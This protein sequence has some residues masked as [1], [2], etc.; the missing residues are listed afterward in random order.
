MLKLRYEQ[1]PAQKVDAIFVRGAN[2]N[3]WLQAIS[4]LRIALQELQC[5]VVP[6]SIKV[7]EPAG[8]F[9]IMPGNKEFAD[10]FVLGPYAKVG[11]KLFIPHNSSLYPVIDINELNELLLWDYQF[12][13]PS[14]GLIGFEKK[15]R[16]D[17]VSLICEINLASTDWSF[18]NIG[19]P[20]RP[21]LTQ[22]LVQQP[23]MQEILESFK[24]EIDEKPL[25]EIPKEGGTNFFEKAFDEFKWLL[26]KGI[27]GIASLSEKILNFGNNQDSKHPISGK[28]GVIQELKQWLIQNI[29]NIEKKRSDELNRLLRMFDENTDKALQYAIPL[30]SPYLKRGSGLKSHSLVRRSLNFNLRNLGGG[31]AVDGWDVSNH[32]YDLRAKYLKAAEKE[33]AQ[34]DFRKAA[35]VYAHL[36]GDYHSAANVLEQG[37]FYREAAAL[38]KD[39]FKNKVAAAECLERGGLFHEA[40]PLFEEVN[41]Y[42][43]VG[44]LY[45]LLSQKERAYSYYQKTLDIKLA[46]NDYLDAARI[47]EQKM[48]NSDNAKEILLT[49]WKGYH[50]TEQCLNGY[51]DLVQST[52]SD[53]IS[54]KVHEVYHYCTPPSKRSVF[55]SVLNRVNQKTGEKNNS[56]REIAYEIVSDEAT[57]G[58][59]L[60][61]HN[62]KQF[63]KEDRLLGSDCSRYTNNIKTKNVLVN[64]DQFLHLDQS[65]RWIKAVS[66]R[67]QFIAIGLKNDFLHMARANWYG[68]VEYHS[69]TAPVKPNTRFS[70][71]LSQFYSKHVM[72]QSSGELPITSKKLLKNKYF[73]D[74]IILHCPVWLHKNPGQ[75]VITDKEELCKLEIQDK[76]ATIH[77][78][79]IH[80]DLKKSIDCKT[81]K[82]TS[83]GTLASN[84]VTIIHD[85]CFYTYRDKQFIV[86]AGTNIKI[87]PFHTILRMFA[88]SNEF[89]I[90]NIVISTNKGCILCKPEKDKLIISEDFFAT[91]LIPSLILFIAENKF[92]II[93][94]KK[95][96]LFFINGGKADFVKEF[97]TQ[98]KIA[99]AIPSSRSEFGLLEENGKITLCKIES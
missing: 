25:S 94:K 73:N 56:Y 70:F 43:K 60:L 39:H 45:D 76:K 54:E 36:L 75:F 86:I 15:D 11:E 88:A 21:A 47:A 37:K 7:N 61:V 5:F 63:V 67:N 97:Q 79:S 58:N 14:I 46:N 93:E 55:L 4:S 69:W 65:I 87:Y 12:Y 8:M 84:P 96:F 9:I 89:A 62:L 2:I 51:F 42:E 28:A 82:G 22:I 6:V 72:L 74:V 85:E 27:F 48:K 90:L 66:H 95:A 31:Y 17:F 53:K 50:Q 98:D 92:L 38:H 44:D 29:S 20:Q 33:I 18:A 19:L 99:S 78:Y 3:T 59:M 71:T 52:D 34:K 68:N 41:R 16:I 80:G 49:G 81:P 57:K 77:Y 1:I 26:F 83:L 13:H 40:I 23:G 35:Y 30:D 32:Y 10:Q 24:K 64:S 91:D